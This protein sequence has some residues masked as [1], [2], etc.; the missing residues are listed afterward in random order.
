MTKKEIAYIKKHTARFL[1]WE[2]EERKEAHQA[3][4]TEEREDHL[5]QAR[6]CECAANTLLNLLVDLNDKAS[7]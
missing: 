7:A 5:L 6:L 4:T 1:K 3:E 2:E